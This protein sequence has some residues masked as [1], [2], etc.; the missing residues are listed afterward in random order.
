M[1]YV[2]L[3]AALLIVAPVAAQSATDPAGDTAAWHPHQMRGA[4]TYG[5]TLTAGTGTADATMDLLGLEFASDDD[6]LRIHVELAEVHAQL[7]GLADQSQGD[8]V[9]IQVNWDGAGGDSVASARAFI[10]GP[11]DSVRAM[12]YTDHGECPIF[13]MH[14][15]GFTF[16]PGAPGKVT[17]HIPWDYLTDD[18]LEVEDPQGLVSVVRGVNEGRGLHAGIGGAATP[19]SYW[20]INH[21]D[22]GMHFYD[23][24]SRPSPGALIRGAGGY[25]AES[26]GVLDAVVAFG[27]EQVPG[28]DIGIVEAVPAA[29]ALYL[30]IEA[31]G[32]PTARHEVNINTQIIWNERIAYA[33]VSGYD[34]DYRGML[35]ICT[36]GSG[37]CEWTADRLPATLDGDRLLFSVP[38]SSLGNPGDGDVLHSVAVFSTAFDEFET[39]SGAVSANSRSIVGGDFAYVRPV[40][41]DSPPAPFV[42]ARLHH[43]TDPTGDVDA[44]VVNAIVTQAA[45][46]NLQHLDLTSAAVSPRLDGFEVQLGLDDLSGGLTVP[47]GYDAMAYVMAFDAPTGSHMAAVV[48]ERDA[49][50]QSFCAV[51]NLVFAD[52]PGDPRDLLRIEIESVISS[53][54]PNDAAPGG[55]AQGTSSHL[56]LYPVPECFPD[57]VIDASDI[58]A[59]TV[60]FRNEGTGWVGVMAD[61]VSGEPVTLTMLT[62]STSV[63][64][65]PFGLESFW[66]I[67][68]VAAAVLFALVGLLAVRLRRRVLTR[69]LSRVKQAEANPD[70]AMRE[71]LLAE[72]RA[73]LH[74]SLARGRI[75]EGHFVVVENA[76]ER[77]LAQA[78]L[79]TLAD[80]FHELPYR[81]LQRLHTMLHD[82]VLGP[83]DK[84]RFLAL[85]EDVDM[86]QDARQRVARKIAHWAEPPNSTA[87]S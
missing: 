6:A 29:D 63:W 10:F 62:E 87:R 20:L 13:C 86:T 60:L 76:L 56:I 74:Q 78:R 55:A 2:L 52:A 34:G 14:P 3:V 24:T 28:V 22:W 4:V 32:F 9:T 26:T 47:T 53:G 21:R 39:G 84:A 18:L 49:L 70:S 77:P 7:D 37:G 66:D 75:A 25:E 23:W 33:T 15:V 16:E 44:G 43:W 61:E 5:D 82:G 72:I 36:V 68:G 41:M 67:T 69:Y 46:S 71:Q 19:G 12:L 42:A 64:A 30:A 58:K 27:P 17:F 8:V 81:L 11:A 1:R 40:V 48:K 57:G 65:T 79:E 35:N 73:D 85:L 45:S 51:D 50:P 59:A 83:S 80:D 31:P 54:T 38:R